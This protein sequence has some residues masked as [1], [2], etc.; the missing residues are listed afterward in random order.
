MRNDEK[1]KPILCRIVKTGAKR[2]QAAAY[3]AAHGG[4]LAVRYGD[5]SEGTETLPLALKISRK[6]H[7]ARERER[8]RV[9]AEAV[10]G[11]TVTAKAFRKIVEKEIGK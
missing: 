5:G 10:D 11:K 2:G 4:L 3:S 9:L 7:T 1:Q 8:C 6:P